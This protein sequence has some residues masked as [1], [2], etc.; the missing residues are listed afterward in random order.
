MNSLKRQASKAERFAA[1]RDELRMRLRVVLASRMATMD[2]DQARLQQEITAL[3]ERINGWATEIGAKEASQHTLTERGYELDR[4]GQEAQTQANAAALELERATA[5]ERGNAERVAELEVRIEAAGAELEAT[6]TQLGGIA[7]EKAQQHLFLETAAGEAKAF[8]QKV[9]AR[10]QEAR[11]A[12]DEVFKVERELETSRRHAMNLLTLAGNARN[13]TAQGEESL[14]ALEREAE[15]LQAEM[16][17]A[18]NEFENLGVQNGQARQ[19]FE[20]AAE[21]LKRLEGEIA[22]LRA[23]LQAN[24]A[25]ENSLR[26]RA[27]QLRSNAEP[28]RR[29][30]TRTA[31]P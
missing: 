19:K 23:G 8:R 9:E 24:R 30:R 10:Q 5:R 29:R 27:N 16:G 12:A 31:R 18:R 3:T 1:V 11:T 22:A 21:A 2:A 7:E 14:A 4:E 20:T 13:H 26:T 28:R 15:R 6:K 17:Q 25:E